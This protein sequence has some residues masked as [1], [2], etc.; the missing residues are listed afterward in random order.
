MSNTLERS[1]RQHGLLNNEIPLTRY[2]LIVGAA[3]LARAIANF[4]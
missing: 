1:L 2:F 3:L 4:W